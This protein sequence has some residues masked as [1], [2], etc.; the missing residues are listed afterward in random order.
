MVGLHARNRQAQRNLRKFIKTTKKNKQQNSFC[1]ISRCR[2]AT[3]N[4]Q[5]VGVE[6]D[7]SCTDCF[8]LSQLLFGVILSC[9]LFIPV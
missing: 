9:F 6:A 4:S 3:I 1:R 8:L 7:V 2:L 5:V